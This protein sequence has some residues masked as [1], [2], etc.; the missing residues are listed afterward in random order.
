MIA[1][2][3]D[4]MPDHPL[5]HDMSLLRP[6]RFGMGREVGGVNCRVRYLNK[7]CR[8]HQR[9][10]LMKRVLGVSRRRI[11]E[12]MNSRKKFRAL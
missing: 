4:I 7:L 9:K 11:N 6:N 1:T 8:L 5:A 3:I 2:L 10:A 12:S